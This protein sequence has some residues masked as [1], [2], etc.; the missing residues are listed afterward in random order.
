[1]DGMGSSMLGVVLAFDGEEGVLPVRL[2]AP[3]ARLSST[4]ASEEDE[5]GERPA[6]FSA[7][8]N[9]L[10]VVLSLTVTAIVRQPPSCQKARLFTGRA[11]RYVPAA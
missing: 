4:Y 5:Q 1:V 6:A 7:V 3:G 10:V 8:A 11:P 2:G 9:Q